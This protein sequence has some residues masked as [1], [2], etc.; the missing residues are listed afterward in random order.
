MIDYMKGLQV[1]FLVLE[2]KSCGYKCLLYNTPKDIF[3][4]YTGCP[5]PEM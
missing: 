5:T 3:L 2:N 1:L 4:N